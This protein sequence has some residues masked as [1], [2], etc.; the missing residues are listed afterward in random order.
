MQIPAP[1][2]SI[3]PR[4]P[5]RLR[6][7]V[8]SLLLAG[9]AAVPCAGQRDLP[10]VVRT[11]L[12]DAERYRE[13]G[14]VDDAIAAYERALELGP[15]TTAAYL[16]LGAL[17]HENGSRERALEVFQ[18]GL[19]VEPDDQDLLFNAAVTSLELDRLEAALS[20]AQRGSGRRGADVRFDQLRAAVLRRLD[21]HE[22]SVRA[23]EDARRKSPRD[24]RILY[25]LGNAY[26]DV[27]RAEDSIRAYR[28]ALER[29][30]DFLR[31]RYNLG[32]VLF[33]Q[34]RY[35][36]ALSEYGLALAP[37]IEAFEN[38]QDVDPVH[39]RAFRNLGAI[40]VQNESW[41]GASVAY[42]RAVSLQPEDP[43][44]QFQLGMVRFRLGDAEAARSALERVLE[45]SDEG[46][47]TAHLVLAKIARQ[48]ERH[49]DA[50]R[51]AEVAVEELDGSDRE[52]ALVLLAE[53]RSLLGRS[54]EARDAYRRL[55][56]LAPD[57]VEALVGLG[58]ELRRSGR[59][60]EARPLLQRARELAP[61]HPAV[62]LELASLARQDGDRDLERRLYDEILSDRDLWPVRL[63]LALLL[64][65][66]GD[67][68]GARD[69][70]RR[71]LPDEAGAGP[72][73]GPEVRDTVATVYGSVLIRQGDLAAAESVFSRVEGG[74]SGAS[75]REAQGVLA[76]LRGDLETAARTLG[77]LPLDLPASRGNLGQVLWL[78]GRDEE[79]APLLQAAA[80][81]SPSAVPLAAALADLAWRGG[82]REEAVRRFEA[83]ERVCRGGQAEPDRAEVRGGRYRIS[84]GSAAAHQE[85]CTWSNKALAR[86]RVAEASSRL[87]RSPS[88]AARLADRALAGGVEGPDRDLALLV[89]GSVRAG[90]PD[91]RAA[92]SDL[93]EALS[94]ELSARARLVGL[95][96]LG[97]AKLRE[98]DRTGAL[99]D[100]EAALRAT[101]DP[102]E[103]AIWAAARAYDHPGGDL[104][105]ARE[106][107][108]VLAAG[109]G[110]RAGEAAE[111]AESLRS[112]VR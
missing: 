40:H 73:P 10:E 70:L 106:L 98:G 87:G 9:L 60:E 21:R 26:H 76:A 68:A 75:A 84:V 16:S 29:D 12:E 56:D 65:R 92:I 62:A 35:A 43:S 44:S 38:G 71:I 51:H 4:F 52:D 34:G 28:D 95:T 88:E 36:E 91:A 48:D 30:G 111:R 5:K 49:E 45:L 46:R 104:T 67:T 99:R 27:G 63:N 3:G 89:R 103:P 112:F 58:I 93:E 2:R 107:Y 32:A 96:N 25:A 14:R 82:D 81:A 53:T 101:S 6:V 8:A 66:E 22:E 105:R 86:L 42:A 7:A 90:E 55:L 54:E 11:L 47:P 79:A 78:L 24:P 108:L 83:V 80:E 110:P 109:S 61:G 1:C 64:L 102:P 77:E 20:L 19:E 15:A 31:A 57:R 94:G 59:V 69:Q 13:S 39:A 37:I 74:D 97:V 33:E 23:L 17:L 85:L 100:L 18:A 72:E 50:T 41:E